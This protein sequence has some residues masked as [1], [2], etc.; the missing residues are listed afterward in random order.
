MYNPSVLFD[1]CTLYSDRNLINR[2]NVVEEVKTK[3]S[4]CK[5]FFNIEIEARVVAATLNM[6]Q[7]SAINDKP[8][9]SKLPKSLKHASLATQKEFLKDLSSK[10]VDKFIL[11]EDKV[12]VL[13][14]KLE[15]ETT[16]SETASNGRF[17]CRYPECPKLFVHNGKRRIDHETTHGLHVDKLQS[18]T[19]DTS[20]LSTNRDDM[21]SSSMA[22]CSFISVMQC[23]KGMVSV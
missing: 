19:Q 2:R 21:F 20:S 18:T 11:H 6:M 4:A 13:I 17:P 7:L 16:S 23:Q 14:K 1:Q 22:C 8:E 3:F 12:N 9:E 10:I 5:Q 15:K